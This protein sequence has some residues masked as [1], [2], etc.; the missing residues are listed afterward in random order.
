[1]S[2]FGSFTVFIKKSCITNNLAELVRFSNIK[3]IISPEPGVLPSLTR[4]VVVVRRVGGIKVITETVP[5]RRY[6]DARLNTRANKQRTP[7]LNEYAAPRF[8]TVIVSRSV[9]G[10]VLAVRSQVTL[11]MSGSAESFYLL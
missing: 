2:S 6:P 3:H 9:F 4:F 8:Q 10:G 7:A 11:E 5:K 1:M